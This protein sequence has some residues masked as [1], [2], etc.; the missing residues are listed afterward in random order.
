[1]LFKIMIA[2]C[3]F[4]ANSVLCRVALSDY[5]I[6]PIS[7]SLI[8]VASGA[9]TLFFFYLIYRYKKKDKQSNLEWNLMNGIFLAIYM[10]VFSLAYLKIDT[11]VGA[12]LLFGSVQISMTIYGIFHGELINIKRGI[13]LV[14]ALLG[15]LFLLLPGS[16]TP[17]LFYSSMMFLSGLAWAGYS[18]RGKYM[19]NPL[20]STFTNFLIATPVVLFAL[21]LIPHESYILPKGIVLAILSGSLASSGAYVL[22]YLIM[23]KI[24]QVTAS[25]VQLSVPCL[26]I[27]G[28][29][30]FIGEVL[31]WRII[32]STLVVLIG[33]S[34]VI[35]SSK[36]PKIL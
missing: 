19:N 11:G 36:K 16:N 31:N 23:Q 7:F 17:D 9:I 15:I 8:R 29:T 3:A 10:V 30:L 27:I 6:D 32:I 24:E 26:A 35:F 5:Q 22:W 12:L 34:L 28:G 18:I 20:I 1:M 4:A 33:I 13:G 2:M 14:I 25:A 21:F